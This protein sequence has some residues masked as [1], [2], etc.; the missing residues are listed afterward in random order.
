MALEGLRARSVMCIAGRLLM[1]G[2]KKR[3]EDGFKEGVG[4]WW[5]GDG[6]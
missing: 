5:E 1:S 3:G 4:G 2:R 6:F